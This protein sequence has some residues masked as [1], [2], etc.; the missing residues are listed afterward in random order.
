MSKLD[1]EIL[2][3]LGPAPEAPADARFLGWDF[4]HSARQEYNTKRRIYEDA[5][6]R[7]ADR[8]VDQ[9]M[10]PYRDMTLGQLGTLSGI[11]PGEIAEKN[12]YRSVEAPSSVPSYKY[13]E[14]VNEPLTVRQQM[15]GPPRTYFEQ[16]PGAPITDPYYKDTPHLAA[17][18]QEQGK[19]QIEG[20]RP[21][22]TYTEEMPTGE[23]QEPST[24]PSLRQGNRFAD[25]VGTPFSASPGQGSGL[26][27]QMPSLSDPRSQSAPMQTSSGGGFQAS[28]GQ[29]L[30]HSE[31]DPEAKLSLGQQ[32]L[33]GAY[34]K[35][36]GTW[37]RNYGSMGTS[38]SNTLLTKIRERRLA[39]EALGKTPEEAETLARLDVTGGQEEDILAKRE[40]L[41]ARTGASEAT[42]DLRRGQTGMLDKNYRLA[43]RRQQ[44]LENYR[45]QSL[46]LRRSMEE[47]MQGAQDSKDWVAVERLNEQRYWHDQLMQWAGMVD[48]SGDMTDEESEAL[49]KGL[50]IIQGLEQRP[51]TPDEESWF[52]KFFGMEQR[53]RYK[54]TPREPVKAPSGGAKPM[55]RT[56]K[57][58]SESTSTSK[59]GVLSPEE[60]EE[61]KSLRKE[62]GKP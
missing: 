33:A 17:A 8:Y 7:I 42:A 43:L 6:K 44:A 48:K 56:Q 10:S 47:R 50:G 16:G 23:V 11:P 52:R 18:M 1:D 21:S 55:T 58:A 4:N 39:Y 61:L 53:P 29:P 20:P 25:L 36:E 46:S 38:G 9:D 62:L 19:G 60:Q 2:Q 32:Q 22:R 57:K 5:A 12:Q 34:V 14:P 40:N 45:N 37:P 59:S 31:V 35:R 54:Y 51:I 30:S 27:G 26:M 24:G 41:T 28:Q 15:Y 3:R 13:M 49:K